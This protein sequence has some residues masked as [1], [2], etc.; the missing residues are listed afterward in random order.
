VIVCSVSVPGELGVVESVLDGVDGVSSTF[1]KSD[2]AGP[3]RTKQTPA[4]NATR[5]RHD[6]V[7]TL[8]NSFSGIWL[9]CLVFILCFGLALAVAIGVSDDTVKV[10]G[11]IFF[12]I[13]L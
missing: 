13:L 8:S 7:N 11:I 9:G 4:I 5:N 2:M 1:K 6:K 12:I 3:K 10:L